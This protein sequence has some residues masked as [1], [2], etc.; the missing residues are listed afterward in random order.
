MQSVRRLRLGEVMTH[1][2][3]ATCDSSVPA[4]SLTNDRT[5]IELTSSVELSAE[6]RM[7]FALDTQIRLLR[8]DRDH[9]RSIARS[10]LTSTNRT[11]FR[12]KVIEAHFVEDSAVFCS[13]HHSRADLCDNAK[14][15][16][17]IKTYLAKLEPRM[18]IELSSVSDRK[19]MKA[20]ERARRTFRR[21][22]VKKSGNAT[23]EPTLVIEV[24]K[25]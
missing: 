15:S 17:D 2:V 9:L 25:K 20:N 22:K 21:V 4:V 1:A 10:R 19:R 11:R 14:Q 16:L 3:V 8:E 18:I 5:L 12:D 24:D 7:A 6:L 23:L 13:C